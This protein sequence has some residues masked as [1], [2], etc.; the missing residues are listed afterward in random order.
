MFPTFV[1]APA[2][3]PRLRVNS[4]DQLRLEMGRSFFPDFPKG[5]RAVPKAWDHT[6]SERDMAASK[7]TCTP[8]ETQRRKGARIEQLRPEQETA[9]DTVFTADQGG[10]ASPPHR[11]TREV[12]QRNATENASI[13]QSGPNRP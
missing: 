5:R 12:R 6:Y 3:H 7:A 8:R 4:L 11:T 1:A 13:R 10:E 9:R 2:R